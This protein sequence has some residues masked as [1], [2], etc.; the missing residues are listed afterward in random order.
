MAVFKS[1][2]QLREFDYGCKMLLRE[3]DYGCKMLAFDR[4]VRVA[5]N[6]KSTSSISSHSYFFQ[7]VDFKI[8]ISLMYL[9]L[10]YAVL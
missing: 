10:F 9:F 2:N 3:F 7:S 4:N 6:S 5:E 8:L 1:Q